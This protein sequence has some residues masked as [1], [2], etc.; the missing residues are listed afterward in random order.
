MRSTGI[1]WHR[2]QQTHHSIERASAQT[3]RPLERPHTSGNLPTAKIGLNHTKPS[4]PTDSYRPPNGTAI[5]IG[6]IVLGATTALAPARVHRALGVDYPGPDRGIW[7]K[8]FGVR[9]IALGA[10]ALHPDQTVRRS[11][12]QAGIAMDLVDAGVVIAA[13]RNGV[14]RRAAGIGVYSLGALRS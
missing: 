8:A 5:G 9:D 14:P 10:A 11:V 7:I 13:A 6:R 3:A 2:S 1:A 4:T 12:L